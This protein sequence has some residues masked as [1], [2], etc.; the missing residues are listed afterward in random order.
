MD[1][2]LTAAVHLNKDDIQQINYLKTLVNNVDLCQL[3][4][5]SGIL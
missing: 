3:M 1:V 4:N 2:D 5:H